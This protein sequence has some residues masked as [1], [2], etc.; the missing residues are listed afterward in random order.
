MQAQCLYV[1]LEPTAAKQEE[2]TSKNMAGWKKKSIPHCSQLLQRL[3]FDTPLAVL[4]AKERN[5]RKCGTTAGAGTT[6]YRCRP[7]VNEL[8]LSGECRVVWKL[9]AV[10][11]GLRSSANSTSCTQQ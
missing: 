3:T 10:E 9:L 1:R 6:S 5:D 8:G 4:A 2:A 11:S 7:V